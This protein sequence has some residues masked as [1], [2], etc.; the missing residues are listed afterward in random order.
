MLKR[1]QFEDN[2]SDKME[3]RGLKYQQLNL[4]NNEKEK[5]LNEFESDGKGESI[6]YV[7]F[8]F[9]APPQKESNHSTNMGERIRSLNHFIYIPKIG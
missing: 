6:G 8:S 4:H 5:G 9:V 7:L 3:L 1:Q 2:G